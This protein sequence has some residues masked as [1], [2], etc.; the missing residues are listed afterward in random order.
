M[1]IAQAIL[2]EVGGTRSAVNGATDATKSV[3]INPS[4]VISV[5][6]VTTFTSPSCPAA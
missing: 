6:S 1:S 3:G 5:Q 2:R 4:G